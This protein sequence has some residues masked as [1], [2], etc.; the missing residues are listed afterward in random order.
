MANH[1]CRLSHIQLLERA[2]IELKILLA[3]RIEAD[4]KEL[5]KSL[6]NITNLL[7][8]GL[9][10]LYTECSYELLCELQGEEK[11]SNYE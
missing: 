6:N 7:T 2:R 11:G 1:L 4:H 8:E 10:S 5:V 9:S 3:T